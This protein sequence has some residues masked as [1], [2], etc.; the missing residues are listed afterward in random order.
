M[1]TMLQSSTTFVQAS[2]TGGTPPP[3]RV[4]TAAAAARATPQQIPSSSL[5]VATSTGGTL[6]QKPAVAAVAARLPGHIHPQ[7]LQTIVTTGAR[8][9]E[10]IVR[11]GVAANHSPNTSAHRAASHLLHTQ[12]QLV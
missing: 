9:V 6:R 8:T 1:V 11:D 7:D 12:T 5:A 3:S 2:A 4:A 10:E